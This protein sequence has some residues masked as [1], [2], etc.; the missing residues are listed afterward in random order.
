V[1]KLIKKIKRINK[2]EKNVNKKPTVTQLLEIMRE[3]M[4][5]GDKLFANIK[6]NQKELENLL[7]KITRHEGE[8]EGLIYRF[9]HNS[10]KVYDLHQT[11][12]NIINLLKKIDP[13]TEPT[14]C[15]LFK[16][17]IGE[18]SSVGSWKIDHNQRWKETAGKI[19][20]AFFHAKYMLEM[21]VNCAKLYQEKPGEC[22]DQK[23]GSLLE[24]YN[25]R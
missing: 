22:I 25:I 19:V 12:E 16:A 11:I 10:F 2:P 21:A 23:W 17:L 20:E 3:R 1:K 24:L 4:V 18:A 15:E 14:F 7:A 8:Y 9:Y 13:K 6:S 5:L